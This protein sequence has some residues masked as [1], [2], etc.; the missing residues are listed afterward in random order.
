MY[1]LRFDF[2]ADLMNKGLR[3]LIVCSGLAKK[4]HCTPLDRRGMNE[5]EGRSNGRRGGE[6][7]MI[8]CVIV[9]V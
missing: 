8:K 2:A 5:I 6:S 4:H 7:E 3:R 1:Y 9:C